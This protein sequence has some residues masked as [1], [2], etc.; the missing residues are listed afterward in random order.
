VPDGEMIWESYQLGEQPDWLRPS[1]R[2]RLWGRLRV[3]LHRSLGIPAP[4]Y[5]AH[6]YPP[7]GPRRILRRIRGLS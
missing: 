3:D 5:V 7:I 4:S 2:T 6:N 1:R